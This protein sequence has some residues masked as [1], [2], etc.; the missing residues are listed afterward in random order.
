MIHPIMKT[1][2]DVI[3]P[4]GDMAMKAVVTGVAE[5]M[6]VVA[7][8]GAIILMINTQEEVNQDALMMTIVAP[9]PEE[10][11]AAEIADLEE[12]VAQILQVGA[13]DVTAIGNLFFQKNH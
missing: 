10:A 13:A 6:K 4:R 2:A 8:L 7:A 12:V 3:N 1:K 11:A 9:V 5:V